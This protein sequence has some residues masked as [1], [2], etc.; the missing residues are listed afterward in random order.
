M[1]GSF[2]KIS[3]KIWFILSSFFES[4]LFFFIN[5]KE[6]IIWFIYNILYIHWK[7]W[8][9]V[10]LFVFFFLLVRIPILLITFFYKIFLFFFFYDKFIEDIRLVHDDKLISSLIY[11][12][13]TFY[14]LK[15]ST[16]KNFLYLH[17]IQK[18]ERV[19]K[20]KLINYTDYYNIL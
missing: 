1:T 10:F 5:N 2:F 17:R 3:W 20:N 9:Y 7:F 12:L 15:N 13:L 4:K 16:F 19:I 18:I 6:P 14:E 8:S 11:N